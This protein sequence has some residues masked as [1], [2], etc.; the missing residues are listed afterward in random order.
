MFIVLE[1]DEDGAVVDDAA[2]GVREW[3]QEA[4]DELNSG[5]AEAEQPQRYAVFGLSEPM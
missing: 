3:A 5:A 2:H 1:V 4:A